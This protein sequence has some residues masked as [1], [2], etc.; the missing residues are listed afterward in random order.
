M[1]KHLEGWKL[2]KK[3]DKNHKIYVR[4]F[5]GAKVKFMK[6]YAKPCIRENDPDHVILHVGTNELNSELLPQRT[7]KSSLQLRKILSQRSA[8]LVYLL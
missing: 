5:P 2:T 7:A 8:Q 1:I 4:S 3:T 6:D